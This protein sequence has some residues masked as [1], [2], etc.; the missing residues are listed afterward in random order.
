MNNAGLDFYDKLVDGLLAAGI[1]PW[2]TLFHWDYPEA[3]YKRGHWLKDQSPDWFAQYTSAM[4]KRLS[5]RVTHWITFNEPEIFII[6]GYQLGIHAPGDKLSWKEIL[7]MCHRVLLAHGLAT[8][9]IRANTKKP[10]EIG[11]A[12]AL[13][14]ATPATD[15]AADLE[16]A[17]RA[18]FSGLA[19][20]LLDPVYLGNYPEAEMKM[21]QKDVPK[22][23]AGDL[24]T[25]R[26]PLDFFATNIYQAKT[27]RALP[28]GNP[29]RVWRPHGTPR[30]MMDVFD[31]VPEAL[32]W[33]PRFYSGSL[34]S[35]G[36]DHRER[37]V[38]LRLGSARLA[39]ARPATRRLL[40]PLFARARADAQR[41]SRRARLFR[42]EPDGQFRMGRRL[43]T[44]LRPHLCRL[45][46]SAAPAERFVRLVPGRDPRE[47]SESVTRTMRSLRNSGAAE[48]TGAQGVSIPLAFKVAA[49][50]RQA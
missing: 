45:R 40:P 43:P 46:Q 21:W 41:R 11:Y 9:A 27:V 44:T 26:Q 4:V 3:L 36:G 31:V 50:R 10:C 24:K 19:A 8:Q 6:L 13:E 42:L 49:G 37:N 5:D 29:D 12:A 17:R 20:W 32:Y 39:G 7:L 15:S 14:P 2:I 48:L 22:F 34:S 33:G 35:A 16:A 38:E 1:E 30:T 23:P 47:R 18:T 28:D 25:I